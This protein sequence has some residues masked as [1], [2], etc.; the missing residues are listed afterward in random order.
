VTA[1]IQAFESGAPQEDDITVL[2]IRRP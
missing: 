2:A 1:L